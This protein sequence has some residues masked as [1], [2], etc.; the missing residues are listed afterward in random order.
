MSFKLEYIKEKKNTVADMIIRR[1]NVMKKLESRKIFL[2]TISIE[3]T[4][5]Q[6]YHF[7]MEISEVKNETI[8]ENIMKRKS[9]NQ[10]KKRKNF[11][12]DFT[13]IY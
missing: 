7:F 3:K 12:K 9:L 6:E 4:K 13:I 1:K 10:K 5:E 11:S 2:Q 8:N